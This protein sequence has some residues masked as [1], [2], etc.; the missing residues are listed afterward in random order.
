MEAATLLRVQTPQFQ[1]L[2]PI[3]T[4]LNFTPL[5]SLK[6]RIDEFPISTNST[7]KIT[8]TKRRATTT[9]TNEDEKAGM[10]SAFR[11][12]GRMVKG[13]GGYIPDAA[14]C[15]KLIQG[16]FPMDSGYVPDVITYNVMINAHCD[17]GNMDMAVELL[18]LIKVAPSV[19]N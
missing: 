3:N 19:V 2:L 18:G 9:W 5:V 12:L 1:T 11:H 17:S 7:P 13:G 8:A 15:K 6:P 16:I 14:S 10:D 4:S